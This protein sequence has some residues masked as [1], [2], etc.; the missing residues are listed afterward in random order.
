MKIRQPPSKRARIEII[1][2][3][4]AIFFL[5]VFFMFSS[6]SMVKL[7]PTDVDLPTANAQTATHSAAPGNRLVISLTARDQFFL[8]STPVLQAN[9]RSALQARLAQRP[10]T[11]LVVNLSRE[12]TTQRMIDVMDSIR[13]VRMPAGHKPTLL[14]ATA[15]VDAAGNP[16]PPGADVG[17]PR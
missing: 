5:L 9:L 11:V 7:T 13:E 1:P 17:A 12:Q 14:I 3:I 6:L 16:L 2:M 10:D 15:P 8:D 4:D